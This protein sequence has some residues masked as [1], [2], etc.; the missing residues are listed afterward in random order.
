[1]EEE[2]NGNHDAIVDILIKVFGNV[3]NRDVISAVV[4]N[5][6]SDLSLSVE[7]M[8]DITK[9]STTQDV[10]PME[11]TPVIN[12]PVTTLIRPNEITREMDKLTDIEAVVIQQEKNIQTTPDSNTSVS[13]VSPVVLSSNTNESINPQIPQA[14]GVPNTQE[15]SYCSVMVNN[16]VHGGFRLAS[17][18]SMPNTGAIPKQLKT[19]S[20]QWSD[21]LQRIVQNHNAGFRIFIILRGAPGSGKTILARKI[22]ECVTGSV[23]DNFNIHVFSTDNFFNVRGRYQFNKH[24]LSEAHIW[25]Q[26]RAKAASV[27]GLSPIIIDNTNIEE[28][29]MEPY[30]RMGVENG[31]II[32]VMEPNTPWSKKP[33]ELARKNI[34]NV[35]IRTIQRMLEN[36]R[37]CTVDYLFRRFKLSYPINMN[38][39]ILRKIP[40]VDKV[41][42]LY[43][44]NSSTNSIKTNAINTSTLHQNVNDQSKCSLV[45]IDKKTVDIQKETSNISL[46]DVF[47]N[48]TDS[49]IVLDPKIEEHDVCKIS[50]VCKTEKHNEHDVNNDEMKQKMVYHNIEKHLEE[51]ERV[52][53]EWEN[54]EAWDDDNS[55]ENASSAI[56]KTESVLSNQPKS[57]RSKYNDEELMS[58]VKNCPD[59]SKICMFMPPWD[60]N[61]STNLDNIKTSPE[62]RTSA[63][64]IELGD[65]FNEKNQYKVMIA[66]PR[67]INLYHIIPSKDK[68]PNMRMLD[69]ST[70]TNEHLM[71]ENYRCKYEEQHFNTFRKMFTHLPIAALRD[72]F[73]KC[74]GNVN[75]AVEIVI[76]DVKNS[77]IQ[78]LDAE[79]MPDTNDTV[80]CDCMVAYNIIPDT[81]MP[82]LFSTDIPQSQTSTSVDLQT[83]KAKKE[84]VNSKSS[85][86]IK[87]QIE[88]NVVIS[89]NHYSDHCLRI[90]KMRRGELNETDNLRTTTE[91]LENVPGTSSPTT[92]QKLVSSVENYTRQY[93]D[94][95]SSNTS[96]ED[97]EFVNIN[98]GSEFVRQLDELFGRKD[99][100]YPDNI[101]PKISLPKSLLNEINALW[102][103]SLMYQLDEKEKKSEMMLQDEEFAKQLAA[104]ENEMAVAGEEPQVPDFKEIM[105]MDFAISLYQ[106]DVSAWRSKEPSD[107][108]AKLTREKLYNLFPEIS[109]DILSELL[110]AHHNNFQATVEGLLMSTGEENIVKD[111]NYVNKFIMEKEM[112]RQEKLLEEEKKALAET[113]WPFLPKTE[114]MDMSTVN[115]YREEAARHLTRRNLSYQKAQEY[116]RRGMTEVASFYSNASAYHKSQYEQY[117]NV[118]AALIVQVH[119]HN[120]PSNSTIDLHFL[121]VAEAKES[122][123][124]FIDTHIQKL[125]ETLTQNNR[126]PKSRM[127][128]LITGRGLHSRGSPRVKP[129]VKRRLRERGL[130]YSER[131]PG[132]L[133]ST[134][135]AF[136]KL[137]HEIQ[138]H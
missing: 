85:L 88:R 135:S 17:G 25:N 20:H 89:E 7:A 109:Q 77:R 13:I 61:I 123:D 53:R 45:P 84:S 112:E 64:C 37:P 108:A 42:S 98:L 32:E 14:E 50:N 23:S 134:V 104:K 59:W 28:W 81:K 87:R 65:S 46:G 2:V 107:L 122:L 69:K 125:K 54:G 18:S 48:A 129:A 133:V 1:M 67:D 56:T 39:P 58:M 131:N 126:A 82:N 66:T 35:P 21:N 137:S 106:K 30:L 99:M 71:I 24:Y 34:H 83:R 79:D 74:Q 10:T 57:Q 91:E 4:E 111:K 102:I 55:Q 100:T 132:L 52:E 130:R 15:K 97:S 31:Y 3:A 44:L 92:N 11:M 43:N 90:R 94:D 124:V 103:E 110:M 40:I 117:N 49:D 138:D 26:N 60:D 27:S 29:E 95:E 41:P 12:N 75:W 38:P 93:S 51:I 128:F 105:D 119:A 47:L 127:L 73:D 6:D 80:E 115:S 19:D 121:R 70:M 5:C 116:M 16:N 33:Q 62:M 63:T 101:I 96:T 120:N 72:I 36:F 8:M 9:E 113:E 86:Q 118:A 68:I 76:D 22:I 78:T 114:K 136:D